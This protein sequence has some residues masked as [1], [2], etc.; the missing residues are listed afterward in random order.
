MN[1]SDV[2]I[3]G[4]TLCLI[5]LNRTDCNPT[6]KSE[7]TFTL[8]FIILHYITR[9]RLIRLKPHTEEGRKWRAIGCGK[10]ERE[11]WRE[12]ARATSADPKGSQCALSHLL[13]ATLRPAHID[14]RSSS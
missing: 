14:E 9:L 6:R 12:S 8:L 1:I 11:R 13:R 4:S 10:E 2:I 7:Q 3:I 5:C